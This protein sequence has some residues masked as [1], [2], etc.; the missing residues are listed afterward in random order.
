MQSYIILHQFADKPLPYK[1]I[2]PCIN[3]LTNFYNKK[4]CRHTAI[5]WQ[6]L[7][8]QTDIVWHLSADN[9]YHTKLCRLTLIRWHTFTMQSYVVLQQFADKSLPYIVISS[10]INSLTS[11]YHTKL[12]RL[13]SFRWQAF[14]I[15]SYIVL[16]QF[17]NKPLPY[18]VIA[19][20]HCHRRAS[21]Y[22]F[23][24]CYYSRDKQSY[25]LNVLLWKSLF[26]IYSPPQN[27]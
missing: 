11:L 5:R 19:S 22:V 14:T 4:W 21:M 12:Y 27:N 7:T 16:Q 3:S 24:V 6:T 1:V 18:K 2:S 8:I 20:K 10:Y 17:A 26:Q 25:I 15:Q 9:L 13:T 23:I